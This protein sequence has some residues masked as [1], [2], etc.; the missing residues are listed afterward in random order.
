MR[1]ISNVIIIFIY[2]FF[3]NNFIIFLDF[4]HSNV[5][6]KNNNNFINDFEFL[7]GLLK[8]TLKYLLTSR[9]FMLIA[10]LI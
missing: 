10:T 1:N 2:I 3:F 7:K 6:N 5:I 9:Y 4:I 8:K